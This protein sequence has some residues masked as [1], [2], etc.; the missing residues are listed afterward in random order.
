VMIAIGA[1]FEGERRQRRRGIHRV[2]R[3]RLEP[4]GTVWLH[5]EDAGATAPT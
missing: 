2:K 1:G 4:G 5:V 3:S